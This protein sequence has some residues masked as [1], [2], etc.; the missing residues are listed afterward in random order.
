MTNSVE[1]I[2]IHISCSEAVN[3]KKQFKDKDTYRIDKQD[4][5]LKLLKF[6]NKNF[7]S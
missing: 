3:R 2:T 5:I 4:V 1:I 6:L 7:H